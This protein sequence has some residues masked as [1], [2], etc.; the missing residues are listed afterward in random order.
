[1][2]QQHE[3]SRGPFGASRYQ[4]QTLPYGYEQTQAGRLI[5]KVML[6]LALAFLVAT[7]GSLIGF[8]LMPSLGLMTFWLAAIGGLVVL[9]I[10]NFTIQASGWNLILL[11]LFAFL[12]GMSLAPLLDAYLTTG[13]G[14]LLGEAFVITALTSFGLAVYA[15]T[16]KR[17]FSRLGD[18]LFFGLILLIVAA[19]AGLFFQSLFQTPLVAIGISVVGIVIFCG[20][21]LY[22]VQRARYMADTLPNAIGLTVSIFVSVLNLFL[23]ILELLTVLG[24]G[25]RR[26]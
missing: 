24:G 26:R 18:Y 1:M 5:S 21:V 15:W 7:I 10:L 16:T 4:Y 3:S 8:V 11:N 14:D 9:V 22:Y 17:D 6:L 13:Y 19:I 23:Y 20:Y 12:E 25:R 2:F